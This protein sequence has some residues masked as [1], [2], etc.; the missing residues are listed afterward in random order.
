VGALANV[1]AG[2]QLFCLRC[3]DDLAAAGNRRAARK[4][5]AKMQFCPASGIA[6]P[7]AEAVALIRFQTEGGDGKRNMNYDS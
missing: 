7:V 3:V 1:I 2:L 5:K 6:A 4:A